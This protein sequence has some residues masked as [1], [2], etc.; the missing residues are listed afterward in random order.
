MGQNSNLSCGIRG[1]DP[2]E[3]VPVN[4]KSP[5]SACGWVDI[6]LAKFENNGENA[7]DKYLGIQHS[8]QVQTIGPII[9]MLARNPIHFHFLSIHPTFALLHRHFFSKE[10]KPVNENWNEPSDCY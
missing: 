3:V 9:N 7:I 5:P 4:F 6:G 1:I 2:D 10:K 8:P